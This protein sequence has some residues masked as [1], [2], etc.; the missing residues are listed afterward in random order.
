MVPPIESMFYFTRKTLYNNEKELI[1]TLL[2][3]CEDGSLLEINLK[4]SEINDL[5]IRQNFLNQ[6]ICQMNYFSDLN[7]MILLT[8][9][10][11]LIYLDIN[12]V[13][14]NIT[15]SIATKIIPGYCQ[16]V[17]DIRILKLDSLN[18]VEKIQKIEIKEALNNEINQ[19]DEL[20][21]LQ[22]DDEIEIK[23]KNKIYNNLEYIFSSNDST[24]KYFFNNKIKL[25]EGHTDFIM[26]ID[27]KNEFIST[28]SKDNTVRLW[29]YYYD[30]T[31]F[32]KEFVCKCFAVLK[33][34]SEVVNS[35]ALILKK[36][37]QL[38]SASKDKSLKIWDFSSLIS[39]DDKF[40]NITEPFVISESIH[41][42]ITHDEEINMVRISPNEKMIASC[43]Y[44]KSIKIFNRKLEELSCLKGHRRAVIDI[45][46]S[47][48]A[49]L[50]ASASTDK[51]IKIWNL[52]DYT[53]LNTFEGHLSGVL[54]ISW[55]YFGTHLLSGKD[56]FK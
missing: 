51:T 55:L 50:L 49:K 38:V 7:K 19:Q 4:K 15:K 31:E 14:E 5:S 16:E 21:V 44:D 47:K 6:P 12:L 1:P 37:H 23:D 13:N 28:S 11:C 52:S 46:F 29:K 36:T 34:H 35:S 40:L 45:S 9:D 30:I 48:Y 3:G 18:E 42:E 25:F 39:E 26:N 17:L 8:V 53:C 27:I 41:S 22:D 32:S 43:S 20:K 24:L 33:G 2:V 56:F 10:Q 54:K